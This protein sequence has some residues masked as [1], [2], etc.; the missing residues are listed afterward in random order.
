MGGTGRRRLPEGTFVWFA[1]CALVAATAVMLHA[2]LRNMMRQQALSPFVSPA[3]VRMDRPEKNDQVRPYLPAARPV[4]PD[5]ALPG[6]TPDRPHDFREAEPMTFRFGSGGTLYAEGTITPGTAA[7]FEA[8]LG[9]ARA[10]GL[11]EIVLHSPGG[12]VTDAVA[13]ARAIRAGGLATHVLEDGY[14]ASSCPLV[15]AGGTTRI[16]HPKAWIGVHQV[17]AVESAIG[18]LSEGMDQAQ[19]VSAE[20]QFLLD[21]LGVDPRVWVHAMATPKSKLYLFTPDE[22]TKY[23]LATGLEPAGPSQGSG[24]VADV[25]AEGAAR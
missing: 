16:A 18:S 14:C 2:D 8:V 15:F 21:E 20:A 24:K 10:R 19:R 22:L 13:M 25:A 6:G 17:Y 4:A 5:E 7:M 12:S 23:H 9:G 3:S 1:F 11:A